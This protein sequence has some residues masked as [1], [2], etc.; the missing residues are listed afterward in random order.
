[1]P[2]IYQPNRD[3][4]GRFSKLDGTIEFYGRVRSVISKESVVVDFGAG[5]GAWYCEGDWTYT[6]TVRALKPDV[7]LL[8]GC[9]VDSAVLENRSTHQN[10][11]LDGGRVP[12]PNESVDVVIADYV[13]E[14]I[15]NPRQFYDEINR[16]LKPGGLFCARTPHAANY[17]SIGA[18]LIRNSRHSAFLKYLQPLRKDVDVFPTAY[19]L[20]TR[21][22]L[23]SYWTKEE[24]DD[25]SYLY[26]AEPQYYFGVRIMYR[27]MCAL[28][29]LLPAIITG[30]LFVFMQK[31][32]AHKNP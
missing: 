1:M 30:N 19:K 27:V 31:K 14:H 13:L 15:V 2:S 24:W 23:A 18:R 3:M 32:V 25:F 20:N 28:H 9:D 4:L 7:S 12:L 6:K 17:V 16:L 5:R 8:I 10:I 21:R 29:T 26:V 22:S 11:M